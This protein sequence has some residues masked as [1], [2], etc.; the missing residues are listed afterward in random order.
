MQH[1]VNKGLLRVWKKK[2]K[3]LV[4]F[5]LLYTLTF[6]LIP[7]ILFAQES[8]VIDNQTTIYKIK[9]YILYEDKSNQTQINDL[10][11][12]SLEHSDQTNLNIGLSYSTFW[13]KF[14][15][16]NNTSEPSLLL[17]V[18]HPTIDIVELYSYYPNKEKIIVQEISEYKDFA[19]RKHNHPNY[20]FDIYAPK[21][22]SV[23]CF[24]KIKSN[25][26]INVP[27]YIGTS[28]TTLKSIIDRELIMGM[29]MGIILVMLF[30]NMFVY[31]TLSDKIYLYY[32]LYIFFVGLAQLSLHNY[33]Y[34]LF[35]PEIPALT[36]YSAYLLPSLAGVTVTI[37]I[38]KF[39]KTKEGTKKIHN[40]LN[41]IIGLFIISAVLPLLKKY[42]IGYQGVQLSTAAISFFGL[43]VG[44]SRL[45]DGYKP[46][47]YFIL[48]WSALLIGA[49]MYVL[50]DV[51]LL[52]YNFIT[53]N[54]MQIG[55]AIEVVLLS[56]ALA[57]RINILKEEKESAQAEELK[58]R[59]ENQE[60]LLKQAD[61][62]KY[63]V[64]EATTE[65]RNKN[66]KLEIAYLRIEAAEVELIQKEKISALGLMAAGTS[67][68]F[69]NANTSIQLAVD[70][71]ELNTEL[72][73]KYDHKIDG[74]LSQASNLEPQ[75]TELKTFKKEIE[76]N[77]IKG[78]I[79]DAINK[80]NKGLKKIAVNT[81]KLKDFSKIDNEGWV[82]TN[83]NEDL[84]NLSDLWKSN[85]GAIKLNLDLNEQVPRL[86]CNA[87]MINDCFKSVLQNSIE[88]IKEKNI[89]NK[90]GEISIRTELIAACIVISFED[91]GSGMT[92]EVQERAFDMYFTT[93]GVQR[94]GT[95]LT[96]V[97]S[98]LMAHS[99][100]VEIDTKINVGTT[101][102]LI[103]PMEKK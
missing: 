14:E 45:R 16:I 77:S 38:Q 97:Q 82:I 41:V 13:V 59:E 60:I 96:I 43:Y 57:D 6:V 70:V 72:Q 12:D 37:F 88:S 25:E 79:K 80:A 19:K 94:T 7:Q 55:S 102:R 33:T 46:A 49:L 5:H 89:P 71:I 17:D 68:E 20:L 58:Q 3:C 92:K 62:L 4:K 83:V 69:N 54:S 76:Y 11:I 103:I 21:N 50:K 2:T 53:V 15:I 95:S 22:S 100:L 85:L 8:T 90:V 30:Y 42:H 91:N 39:L 78:D 51:G 34:K 67:H 87:Q 27:I 23:T 32:V 31:I 61:T 36:R 52:P 101:I 40:I 86:N 65:L 26:Q 75:L 93:K 24:L 10:L 35:W 48:G 44:F 84:I 28:I 98:T 47:K 18:K 64:E 99:G 29:Y 1:I 66:N 63:K 74:I 73:E 81:K 9:N 56:F